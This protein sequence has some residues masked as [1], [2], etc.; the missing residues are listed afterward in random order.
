[1][2]T[3]PHYQIESQIYESVNSLVYRG[4]RK[5]DNQP[6]IL[7]MLK[8][9]YPTPAE[10]T[11]YRQEYELTHELNLSGT[12][13]AYDIEKYNN[14]LLIILEDFGA[15]SLKNKMAEQPLT[16]KAFLPIAIQIAE[17]LGNIHAANLIHKDINPS[18]IV[19]NVETNSLKIIDFG[20]ASRLQRENPTLKNPEQLEGTL[21]YLS[22][23]QTGRI[24]RSLDYRTDLYSLGIT[25]YELL[26]GTLPFTTL[27]AMELV[28]CHLAKIPMPVCQVT[29]DVPP[30]V[31]DIVMKLLAKNAEDR[32]QSA[33][34]V[35]ADLEKCLENLTD[36]DNLHSFEFELAQ[37]DFSGTLQIRQK[38]Y[39]REMEINTLLEAFERVTQGSAEMVL[40][41]G[42]SGVGK[43]ALVHEVHKP[44]T[45]KRGYF[46]AG[47][48]DQ[49]QKNIPYSAISQAFN[50]FCRY[51][52]KESA[53]TLASW[54]TKI[55]DAVGNNGQVIIDV[56]P[57]LELVI[58]QQPPVQEL[59]PAERQNRFK[60]FFLYFI[61]ALC[62]K[63][64]PFILFIDDLQWVD[65]ASMAL[66]KSIMLD[67]EMKY[68]FII[69]AYRD[70]EV[71]SSHPFMMAISELQKANAII[72]TIELDNLLE[73]DINQLLQESLSSEN[74]LTQPLTDLVYQKTQGNAF[75]T[76]QFLQTLYDE[77]LLVFNFDT[78]QWQWDVEKIAAQN[79]T[80]NV[81]DLMI[82]KIGKFPANTSKILQLAAC[83]G[84]QFELSMLA[85]IYQH[86]QN[87]TLSVLWQAMTEGLIQPLDENYKRF[88][89]DEKSHFM[90]LHDRVQQAAYALIDDAQ[91]QALHLQ[92]GRLLLKNTSAE[93]LEEQVFDIVGQFNQSI[94][95][96]ETQKERLEVAKL[97]LMAGQKAKMAT[98]YSAAVSY[99]KH[100]REC[101]RETSWETEYELTR[102]LFI[103]TVEVAYLS[104]DFEQLA[105]MA[106]V[107]LKQARTLADEAKI[108]QIQVSAYIAQNQQ[109]KAIQIAL[110]FLKRLGIDLPEKPTPEQIHSAL[111]A[112]QAALEKRQAAL[113]SKSIHSL[114]DLPLMSAVN[115]ILAMRVMVALV[116]AAYQVL[117][118][119]MI[120]LVLKQVDLFLEYGNLPES[121]A[122]CADYSIIL[123]AIV[124]DI[125]SGYQFGVLSLDLLQ[126]LD[127]NKFKGRATYA[128]NTFARVWKE[129]V[130]DSLEDMSTNYHTSL[131][132]GNL[133]MASYSAHMYLCNAFLVGQP[134]TALESEAERYGRAV[135]RLKQKAPLGWLKISWR[136]IL[137]LMGYSK[138]PCSL[139]D[140]LDKAYEDKIQLT[141]NELQNDQTALCLLHIHQ[142]LLCY[143]FQ[144]YPQAIENSEKAESC[145]YGV[146]SMFVMATFY[147]YD[148]LARLAV[149]SNSSPEEQ[150][151]ILNKVADNQEK[152]GKWVEHAPMN[153]RHKYDLVE[154]EQARVLGQLNAIEIYEKAITGAF[155]HEYINE[156]AL[157]YELA[158]QF[159]L[160]RGME[161]FAFTYLKEA[162]Y[163]YQQWGALAKVG[164]LEA[165]YPQWLAPTSAMPST[166][167]SST[168]MMLPEQERTQTSIRL[169]LGS[170]MKAS[171]TL[172]GEIVLSKLL[173][174]MMHIVIE[175][176][177][178][179]KGFLLLPQNEAWF[180]EAEGHVDRDEVIV[181]Q[182]HRLEESESLP[183]PLIHYVA[184][185][186]DNVVLSDATKTG[187]FTQEP[188]IVKQQPKSIL[189]MPLLS[190][191][192]LTGILYLEN[193]LT[194]GA[195]TKPRL[196]VLNLLSSQIAISLENSL[197]YNNLEQK[198]VERTEELAQRTDELE[199]EVL[200]RQRAEEAAKVAS[201]AKSD[202][203]SN[204]S[205]ELRTPLNGILGY[206]QILL[207]QEANFQESQINGLNTIYQSGKH[208]LTLINDILDLSKI[209]ARKLEL[210]PDTFHFGHFIESV[211]GIIRM[212]AE[213]KDVYFSYEFL[214]D[215]AT[216]IKADEKRLRQVLI[217]LLG[218]AIK[219]TDKGQVTL[220]VSRLNEVM[221]DD[222]RLRFEVEDTG[223]GMTAEQLEKI[224]LPFEQVGDVKRRA[225]GTG[226]G[227]AISR[228]LV[229][230][231]G[232]ELKVDSE[233]GKGSRFWFEITLP[234]FELKE[235]R[236]EKTAQMTG[237][238][239]ERRTILIADDNPQNREVLLNLLKLLD[240]NVIE[241][242]NGEESI[243]LAQAHHPALIFMDLAMP[244]M[245]GF[246]AVKQLRQLND[247]K[248]IP[249][250]ANSASV[251]D[252]DR[253]KSLS[254][255]C[256]AFLAKPIEEDKLFQLLVEH[257]QLDWIYKEIGLSAS[258]ENKLS[259]AEM[260]IAPEASKLEALH[261]FAKIGNMGRI[262]E[263]AKQL[264]AQDQKYQPFAKKLQE[265]AK[266]FKRKQ[267]LAFIED[268]QI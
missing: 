174:N 199:Q 97:F 206:A 193:N 267:I 81:V 151:N 8:Q 152:I 23:E 235:G 202:F 237:Y 233:S 13:Q 259:E 29:P 71:D 194:E 113:S 88:A 43:T 77:A 260:M 223:I 10:L 183:I 221:G 106:E 232:G 56:I 149:Y 95:L 40:V 16:L 53:E 246:E 7:K 118:D 44:V 14:T 42:Y 226:L 12:I 72:N 41:A 247:F 96:L 47:K 19:L 55:L 166:L 143:L 119:L 109:K 131:E 112:T 35:K 94:T 214:G 258:C 169:D 255:G 31:S 161:K 68:L 201:L 87:E 186:K 39:G 15:E 160:E 251:F 211:S 148:S 111:Q 256:N 182:S 181:L 51:L 250:I 33:F 138:N 98:A 30:I 133:D 129:H 175:N 261:Q 104:G 70:N 5:K 218:N 100:G 142:C 265:L 225:A 154:A 198:V 141:L 254:A 192:K 90:F 89:L 153:F 209:E 25:F 120:V 212:R 196:Q 191:G 75:F 215:L 79:I 66:L 128:F 76:H 222:S 178:A 73:G 262:K 24:N 50:E 150:E 22:P 92:I 242:C 239:G 266:G 65:L 238:R 228:Q 204:M 220:R 82:K 257:L 74:A 9:D 171:Q 62:N 176:A 4:Y 84:N 244:V 134:L 136:T 101:L 190:H 21:A 236:Q 195:F 167:T 107:V 188:Y 58:G 140:E 253:E 85:I 213:Q 59:G 139:T 102:N 165:R 163:R 224:F 207:K 208:L 36:F 231:M 127:D 54:Q 158:A 28:H 115:P 17:N 203:L 147:F 180:I 91:K 264:E 227:L 117:P 45:E 229:E 67:D 205:H 52:L 145:L 263:Q 83:M 60:I 210:Y 26:T 170:V 200:E 57:D 137:N 114:I 234:L 172:S 48:F 123:C 99:L 64:H 156:E 185:T 93:G 38:L 248:E 121:S 20:I 162:H 130:R 18:N 122:S 157:A 146:I 155:E 173:S 179:Q 216:G 164:N 69:G 168:T 116:P 243:S 135:A 108:Y 184:R 124:G 144:D 240:F 34:G 217:N 46:T 252:A 49:F 27:D 80:D 159:Y 241:A 219:F 132:T 177:G 3:L 32:Y 126:K 110:I 1:M 125:E 11:R 197:L 6:V 61:K 37:N 245:S 78:H 189:A 63:E 268:F 187:H 249:I 230:L 86:P 2:L 103:D 105:Q